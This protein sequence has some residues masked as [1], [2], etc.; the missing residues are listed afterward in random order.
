MG[1]ESLKPPYVTDM[2]IRISRS[3]SLAFGILRMSEKEWESAKLEPLF[4][5]LERGKGSM[6]TKNEP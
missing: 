6:L 4:M 1:K 5:F 3:Y 2:D